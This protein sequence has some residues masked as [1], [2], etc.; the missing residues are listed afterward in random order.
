MPTDKS[1]QSRKK[2]AAATPAARPPVP[3]LA[4]SVDFE[5]PEWK[6]LPS[7]AAEGSRE[8]ELWSRLWPSIFTACS[9]TYVTAAGVLR[10]EIDVPCGPANADG[11][12]EQ[13]DLQLANAIAKGLHGRFE[14]GSDRP[15]VIPVR[16]FPDLAD[17][18]VIGQYE[19]RRFTINALADFTELGHSGTPDESTAIQ[20]TGQGSS[21]PIVDQDTYATVA[22]RLREESHASRMRLAAEL[23]P[24][25]NA[26]MQAMPHDTLDQKKELGQ[27]VNDELEPLGLAV[28]CPKTGLPAK[29]RGLPGNWPGVGR[30]GIEVYSDG[31]RR[32][33]TVSDKLPELTLTDA[34]PQE[35]P[36][37]IW[38][39]AVK[40][41]ESKEITRH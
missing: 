10:L 18:A 3:R 30:F 13:Y 35:E 14:A 29:L 23:A 22:A 20:Q 1:L 25:L 28:R 15:F 9:N 11:F 24:A 6:R 21:M 39:Q 32:M 37:V 34:T 2:R 27:W 38:Q 16:H 8:Y 12:P 26:K 41:K 36:E 19:P 17:V 40:R 31:K 7:R 4:I 5:L 33:T